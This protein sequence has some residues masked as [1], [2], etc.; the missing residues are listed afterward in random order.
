MKWDGCSGIVFLLPSSIS[1]GARRAGAA[2][3]LA[4][5][6]RG[7]GPEPCLGNKVELVLM[8]KALVR[9]PP[10]RAGGLS[11]PFIGCSTWESRHT[12]TG[13]HNGAGSGSVGADEPESINERKLIL[14][15]ARWQH[16]VA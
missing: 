8:V 15:P 1:A 16:W 13:K 12:L 6:L 5:A 11:Q 7:V 2:S 14:L 10:V 4:T 3:S 9:Y